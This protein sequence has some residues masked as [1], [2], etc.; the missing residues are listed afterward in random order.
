MAVVDRADFSSDKASWVAIS[1]AARAAGYCNYE[2]V[3]S[4]KRNK[5]NTFPIGYLF[6]RPSRNSVTCWEESQA[7]AIDKTVLPIP[8]AEEE[9]VAVAT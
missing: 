6:F 5:G 7:S 2:S 9:A 3:K 1:C 4:I 8:P